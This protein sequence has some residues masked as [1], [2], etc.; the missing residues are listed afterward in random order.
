M[1]I[2]QVR[3]NSE[4][5]DTIL[6]HNTG[7]EKFGIYEYELCHPDKGLLTDTKIYHKRSDGYRTL[8]KEALQ[9]LLDEDIPEFAKPKL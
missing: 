1:L 7:K 4:T 8:L 5:I 9:I 3:V 6:I 2:V